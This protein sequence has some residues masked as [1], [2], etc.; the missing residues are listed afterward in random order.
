MAGIPW[1]CAAGTKC[2]RTRPAVIARGQARLD[3]RAH[4]HPAVPRGDRAEPNRRLA[5]QRVELA[6]RLLE[7]TG[8]LVERIATAAGFGTT[9]SLREHLH[10]AIGVA[11]QAYRRTFRG[12]PPAR[13]LRAG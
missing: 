9:A 1:S 8:L 13:D 3:E 7:T 12:T 4:V 6:R 11:P 10:A 2:D 5:R